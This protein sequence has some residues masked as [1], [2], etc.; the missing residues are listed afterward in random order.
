MT[1]QVELVSPEA[2]GW[3]GEADGVLCRILGSGDIQ[4]LTGHAP[5]LGALDIHPVVMFLADGTREVMAVRGGFVEVSENHVKILSDESALP[6][7]VNRSEAL[8]EKERIDE[9][10]AR[11]K[12]NEE[13][14]DDQKWQSARLSIVEDS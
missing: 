13:A 8:R 9:I 3:S 1:L 10:V 11:D 14:L 5:F 12:E 6:Q 7:H 2:R 4:F